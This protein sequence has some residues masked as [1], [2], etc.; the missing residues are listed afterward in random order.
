MSD[1]SQEPTSIKNEMACKSCG[2]LLTFKPGTLKLVCQYCHAENDIVQSAQTEIRENNLEEFLAKHADE[3]EK[4]TITTIKC[5]TCGA[6]ST[7]NPALASDKCPFCATT[8]VLKN[9][10]SSS[11]YKPQYLLPFGIDD[12]NAKARFK[13]WLK[14]LWFAPIELA[15]YADRA[16]RLNGMYLPFWTFDCDTESHY[17]GERGIDTTRTSTRTNSKGQQ[18]QHSVTDTNWH[19]VSGNVSNTFDDLLIEASKSLPKKILRELEPWDLKNVV[20]YNDQYLSGFRTETYQIDL[21]TAYQEGKLQMESDITASIH[22]HIG[23]DHQR[24]DSVDTIYRNPKFKYIL[25][26]VWISAYRYKDKLYQFIINARTGEVQGERPYS[27]GKIALAIIG[28][29]ILAI[30]LYFA[31]G[32]N[33]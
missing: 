2:A 26:P 21:P 7:V 27:K 28:G 19:S 32:K 4:V 14:K 3:K 29:I 30:V 6:T 18:E 9:G 1:L 25:L 17:Q 22:Q 15:G 11:I 33:S 13:T 12:K 31:F 20:A 10:S 23:G 8:F 16:D 24:I 5:E